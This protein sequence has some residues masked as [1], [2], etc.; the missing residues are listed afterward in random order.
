MNV[1]LY[2]EKD[3]VIHKLDPRTKIIILVASFILIL[4]ADNFYKVLIVFSFIVIFGL[5]SKM[6]Y[7]IIKLKFILSGIFI[8]SMVSWAFFY[9]ANTEKILGATKEGAIFGFLRGIK[10]VGMTASGI[11]FLSAASIEEISMGLVKLK[12]PYSASFVLSTALRLVPTFIGTGASVIEAQKSRGLDLDSGSIWHRAKKHVPLLV[13]IFLLAIRNTD[14]LAVALESRGFGRR[15]NRTY[16]LK[17]GFK[18]FD[19]IF[20][21]ILVF[22]CFFIIFDFQ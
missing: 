18:G 16:Y 2:E 10:L 1:Y 8:F 15:G 11:F 9:P 14:Q 5:M 4:K 19:Y 12:V 22:L 7:N 6:F 13:P 20:L 3:T 21:L 17:T